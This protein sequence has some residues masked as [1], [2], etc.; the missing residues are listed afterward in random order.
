MDCLFCKIAEGS[1]DAATLYEDDQLRV[2]LD[3][4]PASI[5][6]ALVIPKTHVASLLECPDDLLGAVYAAA[7]RTGRKMEQVLHC[8]GVNVLANC[9]PGAGQT[10]DHFHVHVIPRY[11]NQ[12]EKDGL[13]ISQSE[14]PKPDFDQL[15]QLL[16]L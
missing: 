16:S 4:G 2:I 14:I 8:D 1:I 12:P 15:V 5:G 11:T 7:A 13:H 9:R 3:I 6:H 10:I